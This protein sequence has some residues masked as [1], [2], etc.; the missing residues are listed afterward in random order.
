MKQ[1]HIS[2]GM[3]PHEL[4]VTMFW[5]LWHKAVLARGWLELTAVTPHTQ[6]GRWLW[7]GSMYDWACQDPGLPLMFHWSV[8]TQWDWREPLPKQCCYHCV[9]STPIPCSVLRLQARRSLVPAYYTPSASL[10]SLQTSQIC[11][12][13]YLLEGA[14]HET[15]NTCILQTKK[16]TLRMPEYNLA[17]FAKLIAVELEFQPMSVWL[18]SRTSKSLLHT[19]ADFIMTWRFKVDP[20]GNLTHIYALR[21]PYANQL[22]EE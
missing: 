11:C 15:S 16:L 4:R 12:S 3:L 18:Q 6:L 19:G 5:C 14:G 1:L 17:R 9:L 21:V 10:T 2:R 8:E 22:N 7:E 13:Q 20:C